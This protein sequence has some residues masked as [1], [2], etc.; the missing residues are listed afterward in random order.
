MAGRDDGLLG[1]RWRDVARALL[2]WIW[3]LKSRLRHPDVVRFHGTFASGGG[4]GFFKANSK[5]IKIQP[6]RPKPRPNLSK[7]KALIPLDSLVRNEPFQQLTPTPWP[8]L[9][10]CGF[11]ATKTITDMHK[12][13][14]GAPRTPGR[15]GPTAVAIMV[16]MLKC[17]HGLQFSETVC[18]LK[19]LSVLAV[20]K[21]RHSRQDL[22]RPRLEA[23]IRP[24]PHL[25]E[26]RAA[27][28]ND[29]G[30][31]NQP[32]RGRRRQ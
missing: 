14:A 13:P 1:T 7:K 2:A 9:L 21:R 31:P 29:S 26:T 4:A 19:N 15:L 25:G 10:S 22:Y 23:T 8:R 12:A 24:Q 27:S 20:R 16:V 28:S 32:R 6:S 30:S 11:F 5:F 3:E 17:Y 18:L